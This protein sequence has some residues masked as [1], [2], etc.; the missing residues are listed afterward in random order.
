VLALAAAP[1]GAQPDSGTRAL[2]YLQGQQSATD[3]SLPGGFSVNDLYVIGA[4][5]GGYDPSLLSHGGPSVLDYLRTNAAA[6]CPVAGSA[7]A[8]AGGCGELIQA[9]IAAARDATAF[10]GVDLVTRLGGYFDAA[11]GKYGDGEAF[12]QALAVQ[13]LVAAAAPVP[14]AALTFLRSA[15]DT[16]GGWD[17]QDVK[18]DPNA[19]TNF[20]TSDTNSTAMVL[21]ALDAAGDHSR[22]SAALAWL[23]SL[24]NSD[25][26]FSFQGGSSDPD[27]TALVLQAIVATGGNPT[28][29]TWTVNGH[30]PLSELVSTQD[31]S[32]G[33]VFPG[34]PG[35]DAFTTSQVPPALFGRAFPVGDG[36]A[37][38][39][40]GT[41]L[42][43][44]PP[45]TA[46]PAASPTSAPP[47]AGVV[48]PDA[49][50]A[51]PAPAPADLGQSSNVD[52]TSATGAAAAPAAPELTRVAPATAAP[53]ATATAPATP[54]PTQ[55][56]TSAASQPARP[57]LAQTP[58]V[59]GGV[60]AAVLY[61]VAAVAAAAVV[62]GGS[63]FLARR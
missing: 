5:A 11:S 48:T 8:S 44:P 53:V 56:P 54:A 58:A 60:P 31:P 37:L 29:P 4:A 12:T 17:F 46:T 23:R 9:A 39:T 15:E 40:P 18:D 49:Q 32:G 3:G 63:F 57:P 59:S 1:T 7:T 13:G 51:A 10:G 42:G 47:A 6:A 43:G 16:D 45:P 24:Q 50:P 41:P 30:T 36:T 26:G 20:D 19:A 55:P 21:M 52:A 14:T 22:D 35:P 38:F 25:G 61:A 62:G 28:G 2:E 34:N 33:Y 27:S